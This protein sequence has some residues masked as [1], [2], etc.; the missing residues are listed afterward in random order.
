MR[1]VRPGRTDDGVVSA[2]FGGP[3]SEKQELAAQASPI[4]Y[5][6][7]NDPPFFIIHG[8]EDPLVDYSESVNLEA[9]LRE[10]G[11]PVWFQTIEGGGHGNFGAAIAELERRVRAFLE[12]QF[13][14]ARAELQTSTLQANPSH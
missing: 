10:K 12:L 14:S 9:A 7:K 13:Y 3:A 4:L 11:V 6:D 2:L 5:V 8:T 1:T